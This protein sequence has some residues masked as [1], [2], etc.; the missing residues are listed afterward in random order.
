M[1]I[2][3]APKGLEK[4]CKDPKLAAK[5]LGK[6]CAKGLF[7]RIADLEA[8]TIASELPAGNPHPLKGNRKGQFAVKI[9]KGMRLVFR[10]YR[11]PDSNRNVNWATVDEV[12]ITEIVIY[13]D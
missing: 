11:Q 3:F 9:G 8:A 6:S 12:L 5:K 7:R 10:D 2:Y 4:Y 13:H 1:R